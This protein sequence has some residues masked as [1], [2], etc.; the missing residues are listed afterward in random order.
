MPSGDLD[1]Y[2]L[3]AVDLMRTACLPIVRDGERIR[4]LLYG[5]VEEEYEG[6]VKIIFDLCDFTFCDDFCCTIRINPRIPVM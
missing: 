3:I 2:Q 1:R 6:R 5:F 4:R